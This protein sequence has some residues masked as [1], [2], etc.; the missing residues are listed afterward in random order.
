MRRFSALFLGC[1]ILFVAGGQTGCPVITLSPSL[2]PLPVVSVVGIQPESLS[3]SFSVDLTL[4]PDTESINWDFGDGS[5]ATRLSQSLGRYVSHSFLRPGDYIVT[6][7][8]F[9][10]QKLLASAQTFV[11]V[12]GP[13][14]APTASFIVENVL[15]EEGGVVPRTLRFD[16]GASSD[17]DGS[18]VS[19]EWDFGDG[20][21]PGSG[22]ITEYTYAQSGRFTVRLTVTDDRGATASAQRSV[23]ANVFPTAAFDFTPTGTE[24][25]G[26]L[27][28]DFDAGLSED[29]DGV[30]SVYQWNFGDNSPLRTGRTVRHVYTVPGIYQVTLTVTDNLGGQ[31]SDTQ[32]VDIRGTNPFVI[33]ITPNVGEADIDVEITELL[34]VNFAQG[35]S[36]RLTRSGQTAIAAKSVVVVDDTTITCVFDLTGAELGDWNVIVRNPGGLEAT[37]TAGFRVVSSNHVRLTTSL[38]EIVLEMD[39]A[40]APGHVANFFKYVEQ[41]RYDGIVF[42]RVVPD[43]VIQAGAFKSNG[44]GTSPRLEEQESLPTIPSEAP[45]GNSNVRGAVA[46]AL[47]GQ[48][49][50]SGSSQFFINVKDNPNLDTG[51]PPFTVFARVIVGMDVVDNI[52][53]VATG[54]SNALLLNGSVTPFNDV[55]VNDVTI[56]SA[57]RE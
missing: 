24:V 8:L 29:A 42:H 44:P 33:S 49:A 28:V 30:I 18:I 43:F 7:Y 35:A 32:E 55:P 31:N 1:V 17:Q 23:A 38:G 16:A 51:P 3:A 4:Y 53:G 14:R 25:P 26:I 45:N 21:L 22:V 2:R 57:R 9:N 50:N 15:D 48:N 37:L 36:V 6:V 5:T 40:R 34:G 54:T 12:R 27:T 20:S 10:S 41:R 11:S 39:R 56:I 52:A 46:L 19:Y 13:N 47:R